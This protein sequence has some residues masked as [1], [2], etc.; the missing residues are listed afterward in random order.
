MV[1]PK[2]LKLKPITRVGHVEITK[3]RVRSI[4]S[5]K[6]GSKMENV[7]SINN[8]NIVKPHSKYN[9]TE[10]EWDTISN[11]F[12]GAIKRKKLS[13]LQVSEM[14]TKIKSEVRG[15]K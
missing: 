1:K 14:I 11:I 3:I 2:L 13:K 5:V 6:G 10:D 9:D 8:S 15:N 4:N 12:T 7:V